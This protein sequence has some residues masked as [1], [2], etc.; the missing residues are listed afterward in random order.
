MPRKKAETENVEQ[1]TEEKK[2]KTVKRVKKEALTKDQELVKQ[3]K[4][5]KYG[6]T[7]EEAEE[8]VREQDGS[9]VVDLNDIVSAETL[10]DVKDE[11]EVEDAEEETETEEVEEEM[12]TEEAEEPKMEEAEEA[13]TSEEKPRPRRQRIKSDTDQTFSGRRVKK[14]TDNM[15]IGIYRNDYFVNTGEDREVVIT[16]KEIRKKEFELLAQAAESVRMTHP[17]ILKGFVSGV[18]EKG[19]DLCLVEVSYT[20][21]WN[22]EDAEKPLKY[23]QIYIPLSMM[24]MME[25]PEKYAKDTMRIRNG[26]VG[27]AQ[28]RI[29]MPIEFMV[30]RVKEDEGIAFASRAHA[31]SLISTL[32]YR[33]EGTFLVPSAAVQGTITGVNRTG[34]FVEAAGA[35]TFIP[36][37]ELSWNRIENCEDEYFIGDK[38]QVRI[39]DRKFV[40]RNR[41]FLGKQTSLSYVDVELSAKDLVEN[42]QVRYFN[43]FNVGDTVGGIVSQI[44]EN[45]YFVKLH[46]HGFQVFCQ[47]PTLRKMPIA[48]SEVVVRI[49]KREEKEKKTYGEIVHVNRL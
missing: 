47:R 23:F 22:G 4:M 17:I 37:N 40:K 12:E 43:E 44:D 31:M 2:A 25:D 14:A 16:E 7:E 15:K 32:N 39:K 1:V 11:T 18:T 26:L 6:L 13:E 3:V 38:I 36:M 21:V 8:E 45:G 33:S 41:V 29:G 24:F 35:E 48:G 5:E 49:R 46:K 28:K 9:V 10:L 34:V 42:P 20:G 19:N 30:I 27:L